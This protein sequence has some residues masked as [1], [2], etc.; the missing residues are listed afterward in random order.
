MPQIGDGGLTNVQKVIADTPKWIYIGN[1]LDTPRDRCRRGECTQTGFQILSTGE[2]A[3]SPYHRLPVFFLY[4]T[5]EALSKVEPTH[6]S[7]VSAAI[8]PG[9]IIASSNPPATASRPT[10]FRRTSPPAA[11]ARP[12]AAVLLP[13]AT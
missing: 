7:L 2:C 5:G 11:S 4:L 6:L 13:P 10:T 9:A 3:P 12:R 1:S 8:V